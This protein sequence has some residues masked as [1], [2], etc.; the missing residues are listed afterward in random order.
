[1]HQRKRLRLKEYDYSQPGYYFVTICTKD[2]E[3][4]FGNIVGVDDP[5]HPPLM[6]L[7]QI[8]EIVCECWKKI[9]ELYENIKT[10][11]FCLMPNHIHGI[12][13]ISD[14]DGR[15]VRGGGQGRPPLHK[16]IQ[17]FK[18]VTTRMCF[19]YG[20]KT[21]WQQNYYEH[22]MRGEQELNSIRQYITDNST[23]WQDDEYYM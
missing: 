11:F 7:N 23:S 18:S 4:L 5:V 19:I 8:G 20:Y 15:S 13:V 10:D 9:N 6:K 1:M 2:R 22:I 17:G 12:I 21:I 3:G 16:I 14:A